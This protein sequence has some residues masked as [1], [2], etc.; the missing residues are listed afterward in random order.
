MFPLLTMAATV[1]APSDTT[2]VV[3][4]LEYGAEYEKTSRVG[5]AVTFG[6][7]GGLAVGSGAVLAL[8]RDSERGLIGLSFIA[9][10]IGFGVG[11]LV[12]LAVGPQ[13]DHEKLLESARK[14]ASREELVREWGEHA[15]AGRSMRGAAGSVAFI[16]GAVGFAAG[17]ITLFAEPSRRRDSLA[18]MLFSF[19]VVEALLGGL[20]VSTPSPIEMTYGVYRR[21]V[22]QTTARPLVAVIPG[23]GFAGLSLSF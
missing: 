2:H 1:G 7:I 13:G 18:T 17:T 22:Y 16:L 20:I 6:V 10:G 21:S 8:S 11:G 9:G 15:A 3:R 19:G 14:N 12:G 23:G 4:V 5:T